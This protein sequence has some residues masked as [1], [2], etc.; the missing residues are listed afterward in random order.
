M[1]LHGKN[2]LVTGGAGDGMGRGICEAID[3]VGGRIIVNDLN[4][5]M[6]QEVAE[7]Y[8]NAYAV[9]GDISKAD[10]VSRMFQKISK[11]VGIIHGVVNNAGIGLARYV[12]E[13]EEEEVD[14]LFN[15]DVKGI[16]MVSKAFVKQLLKAGQV[17]NIVNISSVHAF[18]TMHRMALYSSAKSAVNA[19]TRGLAIDLG[20]H[21]IRCNA[22]APGMIYSEQSVHI[23][24]RWAHDPIK[25]MKDHKTDHQCLNY[26]TTARDCGNVVAFLLSDLSRS[27]TGQTIYVDGGATNLLY[28]NEYSSEK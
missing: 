23:I 4:L 11:D 18:A 24:G 8:N 1:D 20:Q 16:W 2:I 22:V 3:H 10:E 9:E 28:N 25:W 6:A 13:A 12:H 27:I 19:L 14:R 21:N 17:G 15:V 7:K 5:E 26:F